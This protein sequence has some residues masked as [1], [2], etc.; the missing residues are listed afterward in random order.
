MKV[1]AC[2]D[3]A[4]RAIQKEYNGIV[5]KQA[6]LEILSLGTT[7]NNDPV[8]YYHINNIFHEGV[9]A[10][11]I[12][13]PHDI[14]IIAHYLKYMD[15]LYLN[16][17]YFKEKEDMQKFTIPKRTDLDSVVKRVFGTAFYE[18]HKEGVPLYNDLCECKT[19]R[20]E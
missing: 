15:M 16:K 20:T 5:P 3:I 8:F 19:P 13:G 18:S 12:K 10:R 1:P 4:R 9:V 2:L 6:S 14:Q 17:K 7:G 11:T